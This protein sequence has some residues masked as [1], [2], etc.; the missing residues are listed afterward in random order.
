MSALCHKRTDALQQLRPLL[1]QESANF[2]QQLAWAE[3]HTF[4]RQDTAKNVGSAADEIVRP[5]V[6]CS[7]TRTTVMLDLPSE[8]RWGYNLPT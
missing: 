1:L 8:E 3:G 5:S 6:P 2:C 7:R 4:T